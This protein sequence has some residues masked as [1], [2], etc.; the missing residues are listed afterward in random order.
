MEV[1]RT[2]SVQCS[3]SVMS[4]SATPMD[5]STSGLPV[6]HQ[7][8]E[9]TQTHVHRVSDAI[10]PSPLLLP[11]ASI[12]P[13]IRVFSNESVLHI[14]WPKYWSFSFS[15]RELTTR[16]D[17]AGFPS[18]PH[19]FQDPIQDLAATPRGAPLGCDGFRCPLFLRN[20]GQ[21]FCGKVPPC[22]FA[23]CLFSGQGCGYGF[24][25]G[26][27]PRW[28]AGLTRSHGIRGIHIPS[29][30]RYLRASG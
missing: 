9:F 25:G 13:S 18:W 26:R 15:F 20:P 10:Q 12:L 17:F 11:P 3:R 23:R 21:V 1:P 4:N 8:P 5:C 29:R 27:P 28:R 16:A 22:G 19:W 7:L 14:R 24:G 6:H 30:G 2:V